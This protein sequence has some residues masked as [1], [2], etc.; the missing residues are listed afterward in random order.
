MASLVIR[1]FFSLIRSN[2]RRLQLCDKGEQ[3]RLICWISWKLRV[4]SRLKEVNTFT[5]VDL[6]T[7]VMLARG[8]VEFIQQ[9]PSDFY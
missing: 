8:K 5:N 7:A 3:N 4:Q 2:Q 1:F 9:S 6:A